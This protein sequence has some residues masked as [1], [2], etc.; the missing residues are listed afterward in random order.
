[1]KGVIA[2]MNPMYYHHQSFWLLLFFL[3]SAAGWVWESLYVSARKRRWVNRGF[4]RGPWLPIYGSGAILVLFITLPANGNAPLIFFLGAA[5]ATALEY[6]TGA[7]MERMFHMRYWDYSDQR[8]NVNGYICLSSTLAWGCFSLLLVLVIDPPIEEAVA[9]I[10]LAAA[11]LLSLVLAI[12]FAVDATQAFQAAYNTKSLLKS[13]AESSDRLTAIE[14]RVK[15]TADQLSQTSEALKTRL[16]QIEADAGRR[17]AQAARQVANAKEGLSAILSHHRL[18]EWR[19]RESGLLSLLSEK[20]RAALASV[21]AQLGSA[22]SD[23]EKKRLSD[24][25]ET[26]KGVQA[27]IRRAQS[28][29]AARRTRDFEQAVNLLRRNPSASC[30]RYRGVFEKLSALKQDGGRHSTK[31]RGD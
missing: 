19:A 6:V 25:L 3:Y 8:F 21:T 12:L 14:Q 16:R 11:D 31:E 22:P 29:M 24:L 20:N 15:N 30:R 9:S 13:L 27:S 18:E 5:G 17:Q 26:L 2:V 10:P 7:A 23:T 28:D 4:L 1:M